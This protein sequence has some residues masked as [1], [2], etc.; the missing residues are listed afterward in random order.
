MVGN[1]ALEFLEVCCLDLFNNRG[2]I[3]RN[4]ILFVYYISYSLYMFVP[5]S[6]ERSAMKSRSEETIVWVYQMKVHSAGI[7]F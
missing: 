5:L 2:I 6:K 3:S 4:T 1:A 7:F